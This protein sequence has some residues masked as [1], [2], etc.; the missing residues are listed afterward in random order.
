MV[1]YTPRYNLAKPLVDGDDDIWGDMLNGNA[2]ILDSIIYDLNGRAGVSSWNGRTGDVVMSNGD[3][4]NALGYTPYSAANPAGYITTS[5]LPLPSSTLPLLE[6]VAAIGTSLEYARADHV[7]PKFGGDGA[8]LTVSDTPPALTQGAMWFDAV[9]TQLYIGYL[10]PSGA[11]GQWVIAVNNPPA[12][13]GDF[14]P[15]TGG[16]LTGSLSLSGKSNVTIGPY[17]VPGDADGSTLFA[18]GVSLYTDD[19]IFWN[20]YWD[21]PGRISRYAGSNYAAAA[22]INSAGDFQFLLAP[23]GAAGEAVTWPASFIL[24]QNGAFRGNYIES[25]NWITSEGGRIISQ[26]SGGNPSVSVWDRAQSYA[27]GMFLGD[28]AKLFFA[29]FDGGGNYGGGWLGY[30]NNNGDFWAKNAI[31]AQYIHSTG[32]LHGDGEV[33]SG[34]GAFSVGP[35]YYLGRSGDGAWTFYE[36]NQWN[37][38][39]RSS[40][41]IECR[42][43]LYTEGV[44]SRGPVYAG[45]SW[46]FYFG[47]GGGGRIINFYPGYYWDWASTTGDLWWNCPSGWVMRLEAGRAVQFASVVFADNTFICQGMSSGVRYDS[48]A[49][50]NGHNFLFGWQTVAGGLA[51]ISVNSGGA[52]YALANASDARLKMDVEPSTLDA[53]DIVGR[54]K[55]VEYDWLDVDTPWNLKQSRD[56]AGKSKLTRRSRIGMVAQEVCEVFPEGVYAGDDFEDHLGRVWGLDTNNMIALLVG[57]V[58]QLAARLETRDV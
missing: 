1:A 48:G 16:T 49:Y 33:R 57:A 31:T 55:L 14:L 28:E 45:N 17:T 34:V 44:F 24:K 3:V 8:T 25:S 30:F 41:D 18:R 58:Q 13:G 36:N 29:A 4:I 53:L 6:G 26:R 37:F 10:D 15:L 9:S 38:Q 32:M 46:D 39:V 47:A 7:H 22:Y 21:T 42:T 27:A 54:L 20:A 35:G 11:P 51:T 40:G 52:V 50:N 19:P 2:D 56:R 5:S 12:G 23:S 43:Y